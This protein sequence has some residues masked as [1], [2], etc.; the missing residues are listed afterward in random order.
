MPEL[1]IDTQIKHSLCFKISHLIGQRD[2][3][4][5]QVY[6]VGTFKGESGEGFTE[7]STDVVPGKMKRGLPGRSSEVTDI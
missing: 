2:T 1:E 6:E 5:V 4:L 7:S 3:L